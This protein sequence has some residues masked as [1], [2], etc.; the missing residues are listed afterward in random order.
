MFGFGKKKDREL[1]EIINQIKVD[2][3]NNYKDNA[4]I[5][6]QKLRSLIDMRSMDGV[7]KDKDLLEYKKVLESFEED[8]R[9]FKRTY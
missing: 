3:S 2:L 6:I 7:M 8:V 1:E 4:V 5:N 9:N